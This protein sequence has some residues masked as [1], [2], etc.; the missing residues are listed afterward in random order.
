MVK[1]KKLKQLLSDEFEMKD[2]SAAKKILGMEIHRDQYAGKL[3][4]SQ[5]KY[6]EKVLDQFGIQNAKLVNT[7]LAAHFRLSIAQSP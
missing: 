2:L 5:N 6:L 4:L 1:I 7:P 3:Y